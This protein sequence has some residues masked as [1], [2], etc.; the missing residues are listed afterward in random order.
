MHRNWPKSKPLHR[1]IIIMQSL[2]FLGIRRLQ[3]MLP[4]F[5][6]RLKSFL[7]ILFFLIWLILLLV[8]VFNINAFML[9]LVRQWFLLLTVVQIF[10]Q[11]WTHCEI[12]NIHLQIRVQIMKLDDLLVQL[13]GR[14]CLLLAGLQRHFGLRFVP[15]GWWFLARSNDRFL[16]LGRRSQ[17]LHGSFCHLIICDVDLNSFGRW[18]LRDERSCWFLILILNRRILNGCSRI[19]IFQVFS[20]KTQLQVGCL[21]RHHELNLLLKHLVEFGHDQSGHF[22]EALWHLFVNLSFNHFVA[23]VALVRLVQDAGHDGRPVEVGLAEV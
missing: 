9:A 12:L 15:F 1:R 21:Q 8:L 6:W 2:D 22:L 23:V 11:I 18:C 7:Q 10:L 19:L 13:D 3:Q 14:L 5:L 16:L 20:V 4:W 17:H